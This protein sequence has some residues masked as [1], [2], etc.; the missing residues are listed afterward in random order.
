MSE[1][2]IG[3]QIEALVLADS[4]AKLRVL[5]PNEKR[6]NLGGDWRLA[7]SDAGDMLV[8]FG[9]GLHGMP[10]T[11]VSHM[12]LS[13]RPSQKE[14]RTTEI[15]QMGPSKIT[16]MLKGELSLGGVGEEELVMDYAERRAQGRLCNFRAGGRARGVPPEHR[17]RGRG[18]AAG[19]GAVSAP[20][21]RPS[22]GG[23]SPAADRGRSGPRRG[24]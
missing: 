19:A 17:G 15:L 1:G 9:S 22:A 21:A 16:N 13:L 8:Q 24:G 3:S 6:Q 4:V 7:A 5:P 23:A 14:S 2:G 18:G 12:W 10:F 11:E 20:P